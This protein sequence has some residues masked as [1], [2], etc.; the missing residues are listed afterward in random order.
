M[1]LTFELASFRVAPDD[2]A[3]LLEE[4]PEMVA[5]LRR[6]VPG[7]LGAWLT[8]QDDGSWL[9]IILWRSR[10]EAEDAAKRIDEIP[11]AR[12]WFRHIAESH[13]LRHVEV[14]HEEPLQPRG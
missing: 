13:G 10:E 1:P 2:E 12:A 5:A 11:E 7:A 6:A 9:D 3:A 4:R 14:V 8:R